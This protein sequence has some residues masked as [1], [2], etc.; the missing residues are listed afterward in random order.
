[1]CWKLTWTVTICWAA[2]ASA[3]AGSDK[4]FQFKHETKLNYDSESIDWVPNT[5]IAPVTAGT[6]GYA[7]GGLFI[8]DN[9]LYFATPNNQRNRAGAVQTDY[10]DFMMMSLD[11]KV[12]EKIFTTEGESATKPYGF[13]K[14]GDSVYLV[15]AYANEDGKT[16][17]VSVRTQ[18]K[19]IYT[20]AYLTQEAT[21]VRLPVSDTY[22]SKN[23]E[24]SLSDYV[25]Y[26]RETEKG[27]GMIAVCRPDGSESFTFAKTDVPAVIE[28][29]R[30]GLLFYAQTIEGVT[31]VKYTNLHSNLMGLAA[32][33]SV[34]PPA[35]SLSYKAYEDSVAQAQKR[36]HISGTVFNL[37]N[38]SNYTA[39]YFLKGG[40]NHN[41][42]YMLGVSS[43]GVYMI[44]AVDTRYQSGMQVLTTTAEILFVD[45]N[46]LYYTEG[47]SIYRTDIFTPA[48]EKGEQEKELVSDKTI[49]KS[50]ITADIAAGHIM[51]FASYDQWT[52]N[53]GYSY[54]KSLDR[55]GSESFFVGTLAT[56][57]VPD[58]EELEA[59]LDSKK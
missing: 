23:K 25:F 34:T 26:T 10:T 50:G 36:G 28:D 29:V 15:C 31:E 8:Y 16:S 20:P 55:A 54:F 39:K 48:G 18:G 46:Y 7:A 42:A 22:D 49:V 2:P 45:G 59:Y 9:Y 24:V 33:P 43:N 6:S 17:V 41:G 40:Q 56:A 19:K 51:F 30:D 35:G 5:K 1:M 47:D 13:Y 21:D 4:L 37:Q 44:S 12:V 58:E 38:Y 53:F 52:E 57:D 3:V 14:M 27:G 11:G 32:D